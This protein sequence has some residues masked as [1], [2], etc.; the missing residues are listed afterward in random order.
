MDAKK[1]APVYSLHPPMVPT[2]PAWPLDFSPAATQVCSSLGRCIHANLH[3][4]TAA[5]VQKAYLTLTAPAVDAQ[6]ECNI[7]TRAQ[8]AHLTS[9]APAV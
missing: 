9:T 7:T 3:R 8:K 2:S 5:C 6:L 4:D 1:G